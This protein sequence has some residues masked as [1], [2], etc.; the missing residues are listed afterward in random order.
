MNIIL[1]NNMETEPNSTVLES[2]LERNIKIITK[3]NYVEKI[4]KIK[5]EYVAFLDINSFI[6]YDRLIEASKYIKNMNYDILLCCF[7]ECDF[8]EDTFY[9]NFDD[10]NKFTRRSKM[11]L[12][13]Y[14]K[15]LFEIPK[16][17][18][19]LYKVS[20]LNNN[21]V[22]F[23]LD[24]YDN[25]YFYFKTMFSTENIGCYKKNILYKRYNYEMNIVLGKNEKEINEDINFDI[26]KLFNSINK[27]IDFFKEMSLFEYYEYELFNYILDLCRIILNKENKLVEEYYPLVHENILK[28]DEKEHTNCI[29]NLKYD[30]MVLYRNI[31][32]SENFSE[33]ELRYKNNKLNIEKEIIKNYD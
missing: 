11:D 20:F 12:N 24:E 29:L 3:E 28:M 6:L 30:N 4:K 18:T 27:T 9:N 22:S 31:I 21:G 1:L 15:N 25:I 13:N 17:N 2:C 16:F 26:E 14:H 5:S 19:N 33:L 10:L 23:P 7:E 32:K 8:A